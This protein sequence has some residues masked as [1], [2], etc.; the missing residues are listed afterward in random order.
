M[1]WF[2][3]SRTP[4]GNLELDAASA[5]TLVAHFHECLKGSG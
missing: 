4:E 5:R 3:G 1:S 2:P